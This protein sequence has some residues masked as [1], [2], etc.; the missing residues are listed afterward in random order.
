M[1]DQ[2]NGVLGS[3][4]ETPS[5]E[6][7]SADRLCLWY[8]KTQALKDIS[9]SIPERSITALIG[10]SGCGKST[11]MKILGG[12][13]PASSGRIVLDGTDYGVQLPREILRR[14]HALHTG[15]C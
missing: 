10:P 14:F 11:F 2:E 3:G 6:I 12:I 13:L 15:C 5:G 4:G 8:Q 7:I 9:I 1:I